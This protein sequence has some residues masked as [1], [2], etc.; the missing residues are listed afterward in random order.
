MP[1]RR[2]APRPDLL[3]R[4]PKVRVAIDHLSQIDLKS[5]D[6][7]PFFSAAD[8]EKILGA[9]AKTLWGF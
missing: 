5:R 4:F 2:G 9:N 8:Q 3:E 6:P 7:M 1:P